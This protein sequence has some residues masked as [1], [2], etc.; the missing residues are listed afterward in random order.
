MNH[1]F[2]VV[3]IL[4]IFIAGCSIHA[5]EVRITGEKTALEKEVIGT[6]DQMEEDM[7]MIA[8]TRSEKGE[9]SVKLSP[10]KEK[11]LEALQEQKFNKDD[12]DEFKIKGYVGEDNQ[13][14][15]QIRP[16][17][18][19]QQDSELMELVKEIIQEENRDRKII[20]DRVIE[21]K[22]SLKESDR[23]Q[24]YSVFAKMNHENSP[25]GT[26]IQKED[27]TWIKK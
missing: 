11:V 17:R 22:S 12:I 3:L 14:F 26:W 19:L 6:Y 8:S 15:L 20:M 7:W 10:E 4:V 21:L 16:S 24:I 13:G 1:I 5:P 27:G 25:K 23:R 18:A 9:S 2:Y